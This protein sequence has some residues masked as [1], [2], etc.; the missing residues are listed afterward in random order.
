VESGN[1]PPRPDGHVSTKP[2]AGNGEN[3]DLRREMARKVLIYV[4]LAVIAVNAVIIAVVFSGGTGP[5]PRP[6]PNPNGY[7][8]FVKAGQ[9]V[10]TTA[11]GKT[12]Y[13]NM[14][15]DE[16]AALVATNAEALKLLRVGLTRECEKPPDYSTNYN[17]TN[18]LVSMSFRELAWML[19]AEGYLAE[20]KGNPDNA[21]DIYLDGIRFGQKQSCGGELISRL[22]GIACEEIDSRPLM[23]F[24]KGGLDTTKCRE[25]AKALQK[26]DADE[27]PIVNTLEQENLWRR[28][29]LGLRGEIADL[30]MYKSMNQMKNSAVAMYERNQ[31]SR[32]RMMLEFAARAYELEKGKRPQNAAD[33]V[34][35]Y[36]KAIPKDPATGKELGLGQ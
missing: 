28:K 12:D 34:P 27:E 4:V 24:A 1:G 30:V 29:T 31:M 25:V 6:L 15:R 19:C 7:D 18:I 35:D 21:A 22:I 26:I 13:T 10:T 36:L 16:L 17:A 20:L 33:L 11:A 8:D 14:T 23:R 9:M 5:A 3:I 32:R 2:A